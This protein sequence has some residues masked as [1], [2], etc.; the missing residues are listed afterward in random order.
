[1]TLSTIRAKKKA[2]EEGL[3]QSQITTPIGVINVNQQNTFYYV[4]SRPRRKTPIEGIPMCEVRRCQNPATHKLHHKNANRDF[5]MCPKHANDYR[6][7]ATTVTQV[8][9]SE[10]LKFL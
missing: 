8:P 5:L 6:I 2:I 4:V 3:N 9:S 7:Y 10:N 1:M